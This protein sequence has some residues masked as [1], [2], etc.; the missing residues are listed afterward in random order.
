MGGILLIKVVLFLRF[1]HQGASFFSKPNTKMAVLQ[2]IRGQNGMKL[3][4]I[5]PWPYQRVPCDPL[6]FLATREPSL[7]TKRNPKTDVKGVTMG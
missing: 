1:S 5:D 6:V 4:R 2:V 3:G 7:F